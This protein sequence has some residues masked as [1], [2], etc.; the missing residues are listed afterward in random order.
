MDV[1]RGYTTKLWIYYQCNCGDINEKD[2]RSNNTRQIKNG[3]IR[4][5]MQ[6]ESIMKKYDKQL[7]WYGHVMR[8]EQNTHVKKI[9]EASA[10]KKKG[11]ADRER[12][13]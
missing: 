9:W 2:N 1:G 11:R 3:G 4:K 5:L 13:D 12:H 6:Q 7:N 10:N 8:M